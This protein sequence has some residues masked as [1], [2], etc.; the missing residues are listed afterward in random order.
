MNLH[1]IAGPIIAAVSPPQLLSFQTST[2]YT[3][4][5]DGSQV[6]AYSTPTQIWCDVQPLQFGDLRQMEG[7]NIQG[8]R[9]IVFLS[10]NAQGAVR[11]LARG[12]DLVTLPD[13]TVWLV[14]YVF[15]D[16]YAVNGWQKICITLQN[17]S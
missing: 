9:R 4:N 15:E 6:P 1:A 3:T 14:A 12:G 16:W 11:P 13:G 8:E 5:P 17:G 2:G 10:G 7:L